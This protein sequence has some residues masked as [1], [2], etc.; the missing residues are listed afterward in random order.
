MLLGAVM[1]AWYL[2]LQLPLQ[3]VPIE[4]CS[5]RGVL[6]ATLYDKV[7]QWFS[8]FS[9]TNKLTAMILLKYCCKW[10]STP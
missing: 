8:L 4:P 2:D 6:D 10:C 7:C 1:I 5:W 9:S 3:S